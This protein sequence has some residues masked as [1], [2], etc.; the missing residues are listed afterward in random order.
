MVAG[1]Q[2]RIVET[3]PRRARR[4]KLGAVER[5]AAR[6]ALGSAPA[7]PARTDCRREPQPA[8]AVAQDDCRVD[9][10]DVRDRSAGSRCAASRGALPEAGRGG[11]AADGARAAFGRLAPKIGAQF[12]H[13]IYGH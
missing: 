1:R 11:A 3:T 10:G 7:A 4:A 6:S 2:L 12:I 9:A 13:L 5:R 8:L